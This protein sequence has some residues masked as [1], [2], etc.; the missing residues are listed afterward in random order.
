MGQAASGGAGQAASGGAGQAAPADV[1]QAAPREVGQA[2]PGRVGQAAPSGVG[3]R[4][5]LIG[6]TCGVGQHLS[7]VAGWLLL[8]ADTAEKKRKKTYRRLGVVFSIEWE[9]LLYREPGNR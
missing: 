8:L 6:G 4:Q 1:G 9:P 3:G 5:C 7:M 2:A